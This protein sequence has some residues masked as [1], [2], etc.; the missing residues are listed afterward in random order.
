MPA[1]ARRLPA[2]AVAL[3][4]ATVV[5]L[6]TL[7]VPVPRAAAS[8]A[9]LYDLV[10]Q[11]RAAAGLPLLARDSRIDAVAQRWSASMAASGELAHNPSY[12]TQIPTGWRSA[13]ENVGTGPDT[14][15]VHRALM[16]SA[17][18]RANI[19][20]R[21]FTSIGIGVATD[22]RG[23]V[24][25]TQNFAQ[26]AG[27]TA[28]TSTAP[29]PQRLSDPS[30]DRRA[31]IVARDGAGRL[32]MYP[33]NGTGGFLPT[34]QIGNGWQNMTA[35]VSPGDVT[36]DKTS[37]VWARDTAGRLWVYPGNGAGGWLTPR[38][39]GWGWASITALVTPGDFNGDG[40][41]DLLA[42]D[43][44]GAM[45]LYPGDGRGGFL[46]RR[47]VGSGWQVMTAVVG[48]GDMNGDRGVDVL[49]RDAG[50]DLWLYRGNGAGGFVTPSRIGW[51][52]GAMT[53]IVNV[54]DWNGDKVPDVLA[55]HRDG[56][57]LLYP[58]T[59]RGTLSSGRAIGN[60]WQV[61]TSL[62]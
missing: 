20:D 52:W 12:S 10:N 42:R 1:A 58:G 55:R 54:G 57:L 51:G 56:R 4:T 31:D 59:G 19:L 37:D 14:R 32:L 7:F 60:G 43:V 33:G 48:S 44:A 13:A 46:A 23:T 38:Q 16:E 6:I 2:R 5:S 28:P 9:E 50:G 47:Q 39:V 8:S 22:S 30:G 18:H 40:R 29:T 15:A 21:D 24:W 35:I 41:N 17:G 45:W 27:V 3:L 62:S 25:I 36:G 49:A 53:G 11:E 61:M 26:Y 34:R